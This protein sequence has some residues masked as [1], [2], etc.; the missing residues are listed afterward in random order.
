MAASSC[1]HG[2]KGVVRLQK[3][4]RSDLGR[5]NMHEGVILLHGLARTRRSMRPLAAYCK[6]QGYRVVNAGY[7]S[8]RHPIEILAQSVIPPAV[9]ALRRPGC[10][11]HSFCHPFHGRHSA[12][13]LSGLANSART[14]AGGD[15]QPA[16]SG[17]R[18]GRLSL[19]FC[20]VS[21]V[22]WAG[23]LSAGDR[24]GG[25]ARPPGASR[26]SVGNPHRQPAGDWSFPIF[27]GAQ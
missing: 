11:S 26:L 22:F 9:A 20:L 10:F 4:D 17:Q 21:P 13:C 7:P 3:Q 23:G 27:P 15:A 24:G 25:V 6:R 14:G 5:G 2:K 19:S 8:C 1:S 12:P 18:A 16:E